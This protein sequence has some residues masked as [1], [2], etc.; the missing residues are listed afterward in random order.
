MV[1]LH[2]ILLAMYRSAAL[3]DLSS[4]A[5]PTSTSTIQLSSTD[6]AGT[7]KVT[8]QTHCKPCQVAKCNK[9][10]RL[11]QAGIRHY[12][13]PASSPAKSLCNFTILQ[14][15]TH[16][17][18]RLQASHLLLPHDACCTAPYP[19]TSLS[20]DLAPHAAQHLLQHLQR[21]QAPLTSSALPLLP[22][23]HGIT[24]T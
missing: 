17:H 13:P 8:K 14:I 3:C 23:R 7:Y 5:V 22:C 24:D 12:P 19:T 11:S 6:S 20:R 21:H 18:G 15:A 9:V 10:L 1:V 4:C 16:R 2:K